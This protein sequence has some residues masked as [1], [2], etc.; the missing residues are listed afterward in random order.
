MFGAPWLSCAVRL[1]LMIQKL[2]EPC[3]RAPHLWAMARP[4]VDGE[5][6]RAVDP[7]LKIATSQMCHGV[8]TN[9][10]ETKLTQLLL[11]FFLV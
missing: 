10:V 5:A 4:A 7:V 3:P 8:A 11:H 1:P 9:R 6:M 2:I